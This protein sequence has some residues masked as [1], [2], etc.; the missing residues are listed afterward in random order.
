MSKT[1][2][3]QRFECLI[4]PHMN[5]AYNLAR[6]IMGD[7]QDAQD[8][9][10]DAYIRAFRGFDNYSD[11]NSAAWMLTI[12]RNTCYTR[13]KSAH[14]TRETDVFDENQHSNATSEFAGTTCSQTPGPEESALAASESIRVRSAVNELPIAFRE[15]IVLRE[16]EGFTYEEIA[17]ITD[18][19]LGTVMSRLSRARS[20]LKHILAARLSEVTPGEV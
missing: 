15:V 16:L 6:W 2:D 10:Q 13:L 19:P 7:K 14:S 1:S 3:L 4:M 9:V 18:V 17:D 20:K 12:V 5:A 11:T 8:V